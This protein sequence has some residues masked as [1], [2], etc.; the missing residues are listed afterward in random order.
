MGFHGQE[1]AVKRSSAAYSSKKEAASALS[2]KHSG[3]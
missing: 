3:T 1:A 2:L